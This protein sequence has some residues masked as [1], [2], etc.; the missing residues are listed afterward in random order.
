MVSKVQMVEERKYAHNQ[1]R[2]ISRL[3][4]NHAYDQDVPH[5]YTLGT[6]HTSREQFDG[7]EI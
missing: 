1:Q 4:T 2:I 7:Y 3:Q 5:D 6:R